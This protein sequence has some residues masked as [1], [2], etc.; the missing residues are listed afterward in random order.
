MQTA[1]L[2]ASRNCR[3][4]CIENNMKPLV[5]SVQFVNIPIL[6]KY[7]SQFKTP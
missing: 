1:K 6:E 4:N 2:R 5:D 7:S 3:P